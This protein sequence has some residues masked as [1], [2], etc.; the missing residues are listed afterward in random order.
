MILHNLDAITNQVHRHAKSILTA[1]PQIYPSYEKGQHFYVNKRDHNLGNFD[2][3]IFCTNSAGFRHETYSNLQ[4][5]GYEFLKPASGGVRTLIFDFSGNRPVYY[6][7]SE[8]DN[9]YEI[10]EF[11]APGQVNNNSLGFLLNVDLSAMATKHNGGRKALSAKG[12]KMRK[13]KPS[14]NKGKTNTRANSIFVRMEIDTAFNGQSRIL[15]LVEAY[16][17]STKW[18]YKGQ[19]NSLKKNLKENNGQFEIISGTGGDGKVF[20]LTVVDGNFLGVPQ[21][22]LNNN[23]CIETYKESTSNIENNC[24]LNLTGVPPEATPRSNN[25][26]TANLQDLYPENFKEVKTKKRQLK[27]SDKEYK[28][29]M[30]E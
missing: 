14:N 13:G 10:K 3:S 11:P 19:Y 4:K 17:I 12:G 23:I 9:P 24:L 29:L 25:K 22:T 26:Q 8:K 2:L 7:Y 6:F 5:N 21:L 28:E 15:P 20:R 18:G 1:F 30:G 16:R 27:K